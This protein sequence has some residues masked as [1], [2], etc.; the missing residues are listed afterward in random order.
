MRLACKRRQPPEPPWP[1]GRAGARGPAAPDGTA[2]AAARRADLAGAGREGSGGER[3]D[4][5]E[6]RP[7]V[8]PGP[9]IPVALV[10]HVSTQSFE[11]TVDVKN[12][13]AIAIGQRRPSSVSRLLDDARHDVRQ[14]R[15]VG[16]DV[17]DVALGGRD[18]DLGAALRAGVLA[19]LVDAD[20]LGRARG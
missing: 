5:V 19:V 9:F 8:R 7:G 2:A 18:R 14:R 17:E 10:W 12:D 6:P 13:D 15:P 11:L 1:T 3:A 4:P 16:R 20:H